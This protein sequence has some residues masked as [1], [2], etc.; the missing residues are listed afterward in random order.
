MLICSNPPHL[1]LNMLDVIENNEDVDIVA[2]Y[3]EKRIE[4]KIISF[5]KDRFYRY[6]SKTSNI[7]FVNGASDFRLF[8]RN[9]LNTILE[10][11]EH[12]R[13]SKGIFAWIGFNTYYLPYVPNKRLS[14]KTSWSI[15]GLFKYAISGILSFSK[16]P[17]EWIIK[18]GIF[19]IFL[20]IIWLIIILLKLSPVSSLQYV[21]IILLFMFGMNFVILGIISEFI[22]RNYIESLDRPIYIIKEVI[23]NEKNN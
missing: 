7:K 20:S 18:I 23:T 17:L 13:F 5:I 4:N 15:K 9:V 11:S 3:Q 16:K 10:F 14:G 2:Y 22:Y 8:N 12:N 21:L 6:I 19:N 1:V